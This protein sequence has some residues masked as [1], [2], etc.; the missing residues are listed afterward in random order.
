MITRRKAP[1]PRLVFGGR[2]LSRLFVVTGVSRPLVAELTVDTVEVPGGDG[3]HVQGASIG[4]TEVTVSGYIAAESDREVARARR[5]LDRALFSREPLPLQLPDDPDLYL[6]AIY[7]GGSAPTRHR[8]WPTL[9]LTFTVPD[10]VAYGR[11]RTAEVSGTSTVM[12]GGTYPAR[13]VVTAVPPAGAEYWQITDVGSGRFVRVRAS[14]NGAA[15]VELDM[16]LERCRVNGHDHAVDV[17]SD[18]FALDGEC[19]IAVSSGTAT[20]EW[21]ERWV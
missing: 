2:D 18:Y 4:A 21:D 10:P 20:L 13:P 9:D 3:A 6:M 7:K 11:H 17:T 12:A 19:E 14:F 16:G 1:R 5:E 15:A 8:S